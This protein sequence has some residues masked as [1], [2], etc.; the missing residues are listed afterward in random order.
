MFMHMHKT[1]VMQFIN[2]YK[3]QRCQTAMIKSFPRMRQIPF[4]AVSVA[5]LMVPWCRGLVQLFDLMLHL[6]HNVMLQ[7]VVVFSCH[8]IPW[9]SSIRG[10]S[11]D[12]EGEVPLL[13]C[14][15]LPL[16]TNNPVEPGDYLTCAIS[17]MCF[18]RETL[19]IPLVRTCEM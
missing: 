18:T 16:L 19:S 10:M 15:R 17:A 6:P 8:K 2:C 14:R 9:Q 5:G 7:L 4:S 1:H 3:L 11:A 13:R 12:Q